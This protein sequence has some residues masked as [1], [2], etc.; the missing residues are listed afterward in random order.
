MTSQK[1]F[2][3]DTSVAVPL[4]LHAHSAH[5]AVSAWAAGRILGLSGHALIETYSVLTRLPGDS[6]V[7]AADAVTLIDDNFPELYM[8]ST[9]ATSRAHRELALHGVSGGA[10]YDGLV[11]LAAR[12]NDAV[13]VTRDARARQT[14]EALGAAVEI[15]IDSV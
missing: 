12:E 15:I 3:L 5:A 14:Y 7:G 1:R 13:L 8:L 6:R 9:E 2:A 11:A 4:L 10:T